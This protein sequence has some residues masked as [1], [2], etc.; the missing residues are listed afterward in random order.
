MSTRRHFTFLIVEP[1]LGQGGLSSRKLLME[2]AGHNVLTAHSG[3]EGLEMFRRFPDVDAV[4]IHPELNDVRFADF[5]VEVKK[6]QKNLRVVVISP[7]EGT[8][9]KVPEPTA[10]YRPT[11]RGPYHRAGQELR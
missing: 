2:T 4:V 7:R 3:K 5:V 8:G 11:I 6:A 1:E 10:L 9:N